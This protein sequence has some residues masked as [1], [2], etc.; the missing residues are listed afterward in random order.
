MQGEKIQKQHEFQRGQKVRDLN[1]QIR[2][3]VRVVRSVAYEL[4]REPNLLYQSDE[5]ELLREQ[6]GKRCGA[7]SEA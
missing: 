3:I 2:K 4:D 6:G 7:T 5:I 1:G